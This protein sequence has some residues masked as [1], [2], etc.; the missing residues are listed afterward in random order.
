MF[1]FV[2]QTNVRQGVLLISYIGPH[3]LSRCQKDVVPDE[4]VDG[5]QQQEVEMGEGSP[6]SVGD[7]EETSTHTITKQIISRSLL[8][9]M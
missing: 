9:I 1:H 6:L 2:I 8:E 3:E 7:Q 4:D 5:E